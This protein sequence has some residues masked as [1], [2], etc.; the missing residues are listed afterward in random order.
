[1][2]FLSL[3]VFLLCCIIT[4]SLYYVKVGSFFSV[5]MSPRRKNVLHQVETILGPS[6]GKENKTIENF[7]LQPKVYF[8]STIM[9][10]NYITNVTD[11]MRLLNNIRFKGDFYL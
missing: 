3:F 6:T 11:A 2:K 5:S 8:D 10:N 9:D 1:M 4:L 7:Y